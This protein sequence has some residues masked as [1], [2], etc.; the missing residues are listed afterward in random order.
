MDKVIAILAKTLLILEHQLCQAGHN[1]GTL[2]KDCLLILLDDAKIIDLNLV[3]H[4][5]LELDLR[6]HFV[7]LVIHRNLSFDYL[8]EFPLNILNVICRYSVSV[9]IAFVDDTNL[10]LNM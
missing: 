2:A 10:S 4:I 6:L 5:L 1:L 9:Q 8:V 7:I 3:A